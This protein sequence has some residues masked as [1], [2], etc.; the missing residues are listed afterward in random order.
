MNMSSEEDTTDPKVFQIPKM[1][2]W[3]ISL[4]VS[5]VK[6]PPANTEDR[7]SIPSQ[8]TKIPC[9][10]EPGLSQDITTRVHVQQQGSRV[11]QL[12]PDKA[13]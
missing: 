11:L 4:V 13:T 8:G 2:H 5:V 9:P 3:G 6:N 1:P 10:S 7:G 12:K